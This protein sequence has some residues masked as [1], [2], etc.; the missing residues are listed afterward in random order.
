MPIYRRFLC[1]DTI[2][3]TCSKTIKIRHCDVVIS[4]LKIKHTIITPGQLEEE[5]KKRPRF[6]LTCETRLTRKRILT[7]RGL[8]L[9]YPT[10]NTKFLESKIETINKTIGF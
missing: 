5:E 3:P 6:Y 2:A 7:Q 8:L 4:R 1:I 9:I 10:N